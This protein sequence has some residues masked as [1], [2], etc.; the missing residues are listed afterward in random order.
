MLLLKQMGGARFF[1]PWFQTVRV[2]ESAS[3]LCNPSDAVSCKPYTLYRLYV[4][5]AA[6]GLKKYICK[7]SLIAQ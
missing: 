3:L 2:M 6:G 1:H 7:P 5:G 4:F